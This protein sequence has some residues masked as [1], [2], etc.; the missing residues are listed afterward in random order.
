MAEGQAASKEGGKERTL[1]MVRSL[2]WAAWTSPCT[3]NVRLSMPGVEEGTET[4]VGEATTGCSTSI[5]LCLL[6]GALGAHS[7][8]VL[9]PRRSG[10]LPRRSLCYLG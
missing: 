2:L 9:H 3:A 4:R 5:P 8:E 1:A 10:R 6:A 7:K